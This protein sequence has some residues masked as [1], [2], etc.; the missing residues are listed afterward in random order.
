MIFNTI[1]QYKKTLIRSAFVFCLSLQQFN[2]QK[3]MMITIMMTMMIM[4]T[5]HLW[6]TTGRTGLNARLKPKRGAYFFIEK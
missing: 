1:T 3:M 2:V 4:T 6:W 5:Q